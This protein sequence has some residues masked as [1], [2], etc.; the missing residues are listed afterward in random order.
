MR[1]CSAVGSAIHG[2]VLPRRTLLGAG[3]AGALA[4]CTGR[5]PRSADDAGSATAT[6]SSTP[7]AVGWEP[8]TIAYGEHAAQFLELTRPRGASRG[9]V[10][11]IHGGF[12]SADFTLELGRPLARSLAEEGWTA[13]NL[14]FRRLGN[15]GGWPATFDD[16]STG[17]DALADVDDLD[18]A[19]VTT[20]GHSSG[21]H[22]AVWAA[23]REHLDRWDSVRVPVTGAVSQ[24]GILDL[25][26]L[27]DSLD[28]G[29]VI[30][31]MGDAIDTE[32]S[33][34]DPLSQVPLTVPVRCIHGT[35][36][37]TV[38][39]SQSRTYVEAATDAGA[40]A[41]LTEVD[42]DHYALI[43]TDTTAWRRTLAL[44]DDPALG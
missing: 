26:S 40:D 29:A 16:V 34:A 32:L 2:R 21:G 4:A 37:S 10:V 39:P 24:A 19:R 14:E 44:L 17:I 38:P 12:W 43:D 9:V 36:D 25:G 22:L 7:T 42:A 1:L 8:E 15:G 13:V 18:T 30:G 31:L 23:G 33:E 27:R 3:L 28:G 11:V 20:L 5:A 6:A 41:T 35:R